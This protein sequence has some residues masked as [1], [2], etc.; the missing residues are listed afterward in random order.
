MITGTNKA[1]NKL[2]NLDSSLCV[3]HCAVL[4]RKLYLAKHRR[5]EKSKEEEEENDLNVYSSSDI[6]IDFLL[7]IKL[8]CNDNC[9][10]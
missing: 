5:K 6:Y 1:I 9:V 8:D 3:V 7:C 2:F 4:L 10:L